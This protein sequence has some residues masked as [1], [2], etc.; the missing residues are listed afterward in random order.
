MALIEPSKQEALLCGSA[1][2]LR[3]VTETELLAVRVGRLTSR[4]YGFSCANVLLPVDAAGTVQ[5]RLKIPS[6]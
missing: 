3:C 4:C 6:V 1:F 5:F 2:Q